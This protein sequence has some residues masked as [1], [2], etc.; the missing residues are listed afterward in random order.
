MFSKKVK[1]YGEVELSDHDTKKDKL[2]ITKY[3]EEIMK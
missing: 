2:T 1:G 3:A